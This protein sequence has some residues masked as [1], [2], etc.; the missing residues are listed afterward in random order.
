M[1][2]FECQWD[3]FM[4]KTA[5]KLKGVFYDH[6]KS[7]IIYLNENEYVG[8]GD[9]F[10]TWALHNF[11]HK[12]EKRFSDYER[13]ANE[14]IKEK[15]NCSKTR[16]YAELEFLIKG[17]KSAV[18]VELFQDI[19]PETVHNFLQLCCG[20]KNKAGEQ[21][22]Y[23]D[24]DIHRVVPGMFVQG[25]RIK[26]NCAS[27]YEKEFSDESFHIKHTEAGMLGMC[28]RNGLQHTNES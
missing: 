13:M 22:C 18:I 20:F 6:H 1:E 23:K 8:D 11:N 21:V 17:E 24:T 26:V 25:G 28:K 3:Q 5:N 15:I 19:C 2:F 12:D 9:A 14:A 10:Q 4:K 16:K 27:V 7:P